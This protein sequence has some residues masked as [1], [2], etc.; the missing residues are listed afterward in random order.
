MNDIM[1]LYDEVAGEMTEG[2]VPL[3]ED[4]LKR[5]GPFPREALY[6]GTCVDKLPI[7]LNINDTIPG[8]IWVQGKNFPID[9]IMRGREMTCAPSI[10]QLEFR[11]ISN[12]DMYSEVASQTLLAMAGW[13]H[14]KAGFYTDKRRL[15]VFIEDFD[16]M[17]KQDFDTLQNLRYLLLR[18]KQKGITFIVCASTMPDG[19]KE[20]FDVVFT[21]TGERSY[22]YY[23]DQKDEV[24]FFI[25]N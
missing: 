13:C 21:E 14:G 9:T 11:I 20:N 17:L 6:L 22:V 3:L 4:E 24:R 12:Q 15:L 19:W 23:P 18:G 5:I 7:L 16:N 2:N 25:P 1:K 8:H 10:D